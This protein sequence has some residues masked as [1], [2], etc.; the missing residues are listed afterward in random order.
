VYSDEY[1]DEDSDEDGEKNSD[2][3]SVMRMSCVVEGEGERVK[4]W[5]IG[6]VER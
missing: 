3:N 5:T 6:A 1:N 2:E 4:Y